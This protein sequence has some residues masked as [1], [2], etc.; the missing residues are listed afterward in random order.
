[1]KIEELY[2]RYQ[3][4]I[5]DFKIFLEYLQ[6][7]LYPSFRVNTIKVAPEKIF[8]LL[9]ELKLTPLKFYSEGFSLN[10]RFPLGNH[11]TH[12][13]G[14]IYA[15]EIASMIPAIILEPKPNETILDLCAAPGSKTTQIAQLMKNK[16]LIVAN[17]VNKKRIS[18]LIHNVKRCGLL[19]EVVI[20]L[21]GERI[22]NI[23]PDY[24]DRVLID[25]PC[26][27][28]GTIRKSR[29]VLYHWGLKNI[30][31]MSRIQKGLIVSGFKALKS[32]GTLV[33]STC[34]IA[35]EEN[36]GVIDY[37][38]KKFPEAEVLPITIPGFKIRAGI[39]HWQN[40]S[41]DQR[42]KM[43][44]RILPQDN[45]TAPFF[46]AKITKRGI[47]HLRPGFQGRIEFNER[48]IENLYR[49]FEIA[50]ENFSNYAIFQ[51]QNAFFIS[52]CE[53]YSF[54]ELPCIRKGLE[55]GWI[56]DDV[57]KPD[58]D[59]IQIFGKGVKKNFV[60]IEEWELKRFLSGESIRTQSSLD[61]FVVLLFKDLPIGVGRIND[62]EIK[63]T[64]KPSRRIK[65]PE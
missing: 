1:M 57:L 30:Q 9:K 42:V 60:E 20:S 27:A 55:L 48:I 63:S 15:Q 37:L 50:K 47:P 33:Y 62:K 51:R 14:L 61:G 4:I 35:P 34:T 8:N 56:Y 24:F 39:T 59:F 18:G 44:S 32:G 53:V 13:V 17:E 3:S 36:E 54:F 2:S 41:F 46:V 7:P 52:T 31:K 26:S 11:W 23:L 10:Q 43:C 28:E 40:E 65:S 5:P 25:A 58:N 6:I 21:P 12:Q 38:L 64:I 45:N 29:A 49:R 22:G 19:N 16:G